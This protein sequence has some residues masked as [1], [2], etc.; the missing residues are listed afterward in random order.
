MLIQS[1][2]FR[3]VRLAALPGD[4]RRGALL[5][6]ATEPFALGLIEAPGAQ[7]ADIVVGKGRSG[8]CALPRGP[9]FGFL[10]ARREHIRQMPA[11]SSDVASTLTARPLLMVLQTREQHIRREKRPRTSH[12][13][14]CNALA[15]RSTCASERAVSCKRASFVSRRPT[16][17]R[18]E[19]CAPLLP[20][21]FDLRS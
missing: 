13:P 16:T 15:V 11:G 21:A 8:E 3:V 19:S 18:D 5:V 20:L 12:E 6:V 14:G 9:Y 17:P 7:G 10:A 2:T 1:R 4:A